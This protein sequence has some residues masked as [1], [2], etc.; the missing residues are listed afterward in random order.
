MR[1]G[2][3]EI[4][5]LVVAGVALFFML[6]SCHRGQEISR[7]NKQIREQQLEADREILRRQKKRRASRPKIQRQI[8][9]IKELSKPDKPDEIDKIV[10]QAERIKKKKDK[11]KA[12]LEAVK[13]EAVD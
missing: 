12:L 1:I 11:I 2:I 4:L 5:F 3:M 13:E 7:A 10:D 9:E 8:K 6:K